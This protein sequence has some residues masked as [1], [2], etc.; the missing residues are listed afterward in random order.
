MTKSCAT[1]QGPGRDPGRGAALALREGG[2]HGALTWGVLDRLLEEGLGVH[3][4]CGMSSGALIGVTLAQGLVRDGH[5]S[6]RAATRALWQ[7]FARAHAMRPL[8]SDRGHV[9]PLT[10][11]PAV[12]GYHW[13][14][15][16]TRAAHFV[17]ARNSVQPC[18]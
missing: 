13:L 9:I 15:S 7:R 17:A 1:H 5:E 16:H 10:S 8:R 14:N 4:C 6:A 3:A 18:A 11:R 2:A 12:R